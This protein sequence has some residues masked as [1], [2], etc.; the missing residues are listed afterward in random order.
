MSET[1]PDPIEDK[2]DREPEWQP[3]ELGYGQAPTMRTFEWDPISDDVRVEGPQIELPRTK[4]DRHI[5][6]VP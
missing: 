6:P 5:R 4:R 1:Y 2:R 3:I